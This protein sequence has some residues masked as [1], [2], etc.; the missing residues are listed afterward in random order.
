MSLSEQ[1]KKFMRCAIDL[2][3]KGQGRTHPNPMVG[4]VV[5][6]KNKI[7]GRGYHVYTDWLH[8][9]VI[10]IRDA[11]RRVKTSRKSQ[12]LKNCTLYVTLEPCSSYGR[13]C[14]C[15][16][17]IVFSGIK[18]VVVSAMDPHPGHRGQGLKILKSHGIHVTKDI[19]AKESMIL[20]KAYMKALSEKRPYIILKSAVSLDG[21]IATRSGDS[22]WI[23]SL[24]SRKLVHKLRAQVDGVLVGANTVLKDNPL[25]TARLSGSTLQ[26]VRIVLDGQGR[27]LRK[28]KNLKLFQ[29]IL[30]KKNQTE[31]PYDILVLTQPGVRTESV[32]KA[33]GK[34]RVKIESIPILKNKKLSLKDVLKKLVDL[35][36]YQILVEG[37]GETNASFLSSGNV[38]EC[39]FFIAP[40]LIGGRSAPTAFEGRGINRIKQAYQ[41]KNVTYRKIGPDILIQGQLS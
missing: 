19:L 41:L 24:A 13:T 34:K 6:E 39:W 38:D 40:K 3:K 4:C 1:D 36:I 22:A 26:P 28:S 31:R 21:K 14:P 23:T 8:A 7:L 15:T 20:N 25:L 10:A 9:E 17:A 35:G 16:D 32:V 18:R 12:Q 2:A 30:N 27:V 11:M 29:S 5:V 37:G 33:W